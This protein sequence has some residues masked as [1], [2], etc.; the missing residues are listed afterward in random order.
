MDVVIE[1]RS[2]YWRNFCAQLCSSLK[3][4]VDIYCV[5]PSLQ[6]ERCS[7]WFLLEAF[8]VGALKVCNAYMDA[9]KYGH[10]SFI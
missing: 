5:P 9:S 2:A 7:W 8:S 10:F 1:H 4:S 6:V 3:A